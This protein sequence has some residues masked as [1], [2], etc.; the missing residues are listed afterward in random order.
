MEKHRHR[1][2]KSAGVRAAFFFILC[3]LGLMAAIGLMF[4]YW[5]EN[6]FVPDAH[7][8]TPIEAKPGR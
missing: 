4:W 7:E 6:D 8:A 2:K 1:S 3:C 5:N